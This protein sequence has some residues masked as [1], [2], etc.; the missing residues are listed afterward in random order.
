LVSVV[1]VI[2]GGILRYL[3]KIERSLGTILATLQAQATEIDDLKTFRVNI[4]QARA[5]LPERTRRRVGD[6]P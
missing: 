1:L 5:L 4:E 2:G 6:I 3:F